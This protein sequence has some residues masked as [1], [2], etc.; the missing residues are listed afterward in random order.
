MKTEQVLLLIGSPKGGKSTSESLGAYLLD[1]LRE[2][3]CKTE[4]IRIYSA[5]KSSAGQDEL[6]A[7][8]GRADLVIFASPLYVDT[9]PAAVIR[10]LELTAQRRTGDGK[11]RQRLLAIS[12]CGFP[13]ALHND[14]AIAVYRRFAQ[15]AGIE[16]AGGLALGGGAAIGGKPLD[17]AGGMAHN[18]TS[19]LDLAAAA[20]AEGKPL[21]QE[22]TEL[23]SRPIVPTWMYVLIGGIGWKREAKKHGAQ[24]KLAA[25]PY[26]K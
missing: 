1:R 19:A 9:L 24:K 15:E 7:A 11:D 26:Q 13:E 21:P 8:V 25:R 23:M 17:E 6:G 3:G 20:L 5:L 12:N 2:R 22:A 10:V 4:K 16:W 18:V 14:S